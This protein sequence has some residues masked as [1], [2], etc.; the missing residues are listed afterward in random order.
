LAGR[1]T[2]SVSSF[3]AKQN[4]TIPDADSPGP[5]IPSLRTLDLVDSCIYYEIDYISYVTTYAMLAVSTGT[6]KVF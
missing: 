5:Q 1:S 6:G 2:A 3:L 4:L